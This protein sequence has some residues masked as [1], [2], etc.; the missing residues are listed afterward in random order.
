M[1]DA[2]GQVTTTL[3]AILNADPTVR[4]LCG[5]STGCAIAWGDFD[6]TRDPLP[7]LCWDE[8]TTGPGFLENSVRVPGLLAAF[9]TGDDADDVT[10]AL[11]T[12]AEVALSQPALAARGLDACPDPESLPWPRD[13]V[14]MDEEALPTLVQ[15]TMALTITITPET[16]P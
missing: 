4:S 11:L 15:R 16:V 12:A 13:H 8:L 3:F 5:R 14:A 6:A 1:P 9:A 10:A 7:T 2:A